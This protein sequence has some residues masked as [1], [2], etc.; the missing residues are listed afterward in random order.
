MSG[1]LQSDVRTEFETCGRCKIILSPRVSLELVR[2]DSFPESA[3]Y[4]F[5]VYVDSVEKQNMCC[6]ESFADSVITKSF[7]GSLI[8]YLKT[9]GKTSTEI[10]DIINN[11]DAH[12]A[13]SL[14]GFGFAAVLLVATRV[15]SHTAE[16]ILTNF[17]H[18]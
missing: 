4:K 10:A 6:S 7:D 15:D 8:A 16:G 3:R 13:G 5:S 1:S 11:P 9:R 2:Y 18:S 14:A 17:A 12:V